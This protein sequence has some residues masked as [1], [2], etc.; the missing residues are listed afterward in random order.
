VHP[1]KQKVKVT[2]TSI[3]KRIKPVLAYARKLSHVAA[4]CHLSLAKVSGS[5]F[6]LLRPGLVRGE[7]ELL[8]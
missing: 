2:T 3:G 4:S 7:P 5:E 1:C 6:A 8:M